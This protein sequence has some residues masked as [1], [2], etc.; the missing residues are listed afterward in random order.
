M[1]AKGPF[2]APRLCTF[3]PAFFRAAL[4]DLVPKYQSSSVAMWFGDGAHDTSIESEHYW[5]IIKYTCLTF[6]ALFWAALARFI[7]VI[8]TQRYSI[9]E[10]NIICQNFVL[11]SNNQII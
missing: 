4:S 7:F 6:T 5:N 1:I 10:F 11:F 8:A 9:N 2:P 3:F